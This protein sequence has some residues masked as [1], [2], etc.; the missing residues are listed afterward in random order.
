MFPV[1]PGCPPGFRS[2]FAV[3]FFSLPGSMAGGR[4]PFFELFLMNLDST[5]RQAAINSSIANLKAGL[6]FFAL[7]ICFRA[8][9][10]AASISISRFVIA[11]P[12]SLL[13]YN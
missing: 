12:L 5:I 13:P 6:M 9:A 7:P 10:I 8:F 3:E 11:L 1:C 2:F 4:L